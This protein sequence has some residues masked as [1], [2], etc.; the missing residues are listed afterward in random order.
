MAFEGSG[1]LPSGPHMPCL[2]RVGRKRGEIG[3]GER[4]CVG[5]AGAVAFAMDMGALARLG[6]QREGVDRLALTRATMREGGK[7][8]GD[9][10][11]PYRVWDPVRLLYPAL[12]PPDDP[13]LLRGYEF[14]SCLSLRWRR[15]ASVMV[16]QTRDC[17][18]L[19]VAR[20]T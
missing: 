19:H 20:V 1:V 4:G 3:G 5:R 15:N 12:H 11:R 7:L 6:G 17:Y 10:F 8:L 14:I 18:E 16:A 2:Q 9:L 13:S